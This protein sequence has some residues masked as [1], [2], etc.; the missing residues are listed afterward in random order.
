VEEALARTEEM[1]IHFLQPEL[2]RIRGELLRMREDTGEAMRCFLRARVLARHQRAAL[3]ELRATVSL[4][5]LLR[6]TGHGALARRRLV[7]A[8]HAS[9][10]DPEAVDFQDV[11]L[12]LLMVTR[13]RGFLVM[14]RRELPDF[15]TTPRDGFGREV[16]RGRVRRW[17]PRLRAS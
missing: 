3:L 9:R 8:L 17:S 11:R 4:A 13:K 6:D 15:K 2:H 12:L 7:R 5:R 1:G 16:E 14:G 10:V